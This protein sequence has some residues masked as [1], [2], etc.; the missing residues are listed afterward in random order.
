MFH[1][2]KT[3]IE[4]ESFRTILAQIDLKIAVLVFPLSVFGDVIGL[5]KD[6][7]YRSNRLYFGN[8]DYLS[9]FPRK[10]YSENMLTFH[11]AINEIRTSANP[12]ESLSPRSS[13]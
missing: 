6:T 10:F 8:F 2:L 7:G 11:L 12:S 9:K 13:F 4:G 5:A 1:A 3:N